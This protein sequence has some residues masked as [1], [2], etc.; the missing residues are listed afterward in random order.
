M[1]SAERE[2]LALDLQKSISNI[3]RELQKLTESY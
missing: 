3:E 1:S 2:Q